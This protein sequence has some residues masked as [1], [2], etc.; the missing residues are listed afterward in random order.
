MSSNYVAKYQVNP[1][2][3][4]PP[5][6]NILDEFEQMTLK[7]RNELQPGETF[8]GQIAFICKNDRGEKIKH[9]V[10]ITVTPLGSNATRTTKCIEKPAE[11]I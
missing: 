2:P 4:L 5:V 11:I 6:R 1:T 10:E 8:D 9:S 3:L 7:I